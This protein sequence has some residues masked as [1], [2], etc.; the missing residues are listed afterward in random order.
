MDLVERTLY[1]GSVICLIIK[2][3]ED[4]LLTK[5]SRHK[6]K[7]EFVDSYQKMLN[8]NP[9]LNTKSCIVEIKSKTAGSRLVRALFELWKKVNIH[10]NSQIICVGYP[11]DYIDSLISLG[12]TSIENFDLAPNKD[13]AFAKIQR[14][15]NKLS[16][17]INPNPN[18]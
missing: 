14:C 5:E 2:Y 4:F 12:L 3:N 15:A 8:D 7:D 11:E 9:N 6:I 10:P 13:I 18:E 16:T 17:V 1:K